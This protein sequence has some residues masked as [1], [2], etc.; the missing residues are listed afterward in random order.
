MRLALVIITYERPDALKAVLQSVA[1]QAGR[2]DQIVIGD[3]G[4]GP[5]TRE[6]IDEA[7]AGGLDIIHEWREHDGFRAARMRNCAL[8]RVDCDYV[9]FVDGDLLL[10]PQF[11]RDHRS[12]ARPGY[13]VQGK[14]VLLD[15]EA[16]ERVLR[17]VDKWPSV[18]ASGVGRR[19][20]LFRLPFLSPLLAS[21]GHLK[22]IR[23]CNFAAWM[24]DIRRV[25][26]FNEEFVGWGREDDEFAERLWNSGVK[27]LNLR[28]G[29]IGCHLHHPPHSRDGLHKNTILVEQVRN[30]GAVRCEK[31]LD[32]H[33]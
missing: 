12:M 17:G 15:M 6:V 27:R 20:H 26:G 1:A 2:P 10:H 9:V 22:G 24:D 3:D 29:G 11:I 25:N 28:C 31:G 23:S 18:F 21:V 13:F 16:T 30:S 32:S 8:S 7:R 5:T 14:R 4:S 19:R 33:L